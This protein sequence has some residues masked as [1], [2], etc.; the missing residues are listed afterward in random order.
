MLEEFI[1]LFPS[2]ISQGFVPGLLQPH[3][4]GLHISGY[5]MEPQR[6]TGKPQ[7]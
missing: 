1:N 4:C 5:Q 3:T 6:L 2:P 7:D